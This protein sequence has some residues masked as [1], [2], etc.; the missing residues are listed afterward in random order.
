MILTLKQ[1]DCTLLGTEPT[2]IMRGLLDHVY[3]RNNANVLGKVTLQAEPIY[4]SDHDA[5]ILSWSS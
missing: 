4:Y 2:H 5:I 3:N 1:Y